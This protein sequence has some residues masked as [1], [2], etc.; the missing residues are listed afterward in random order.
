MTVGG[1]VVLV[2][3]FTPSASHTRHVE[4]VRILDIIAIVSGLVVP[5]LLAGRHSWLQ[6]LVMLSATL[7]VTVA[8]LGSGGG[9]TAVG[10]ASVYT[11]VVV[12][13]FFALSR[14]GAVAHLLTIILVGAP[15]LHMQAG[16]RLAEQIVLWGVTGLISLM[17]AWLI[18]VHDQSETDPLTGLPDRKGMDRALDRAL[19][20]PFG[21][22][23]HQATFGLL[24]LD[25]FTRFNTHHGAGA[26]DD[27]LRQLAT[28]WTRA[29]PDG[30]VLG[31]WSGDAFAV[32]MPGRSGEE[33]RAVCEQLRVL[34]PDGASVSAGVAQW[35][36]TE[37]QS[38]L[39]A[40]AET[41][42]YLAKQSG[43]DRVH[44]HSGPGTDGRDVRE[45]LAKIE[46][47]VHF[48][49]VVDLSTGLVQGAEALVRWERP[50][51]GLV[52]PDEFLPE[53]ET[54]GAIVELG[55]WVLREACH[56]AATWAPNAAGHL[57]HVAVNASGR[58]LQD[59]LYAVTV[60]EALLSSGLAPS[61]LIIELVESDYDIQTVELSDNLHALRAMGV[62]TAIDDFGTGSSSLERVRRLGADILKI[63]KSFVSDI[64]CAQT[65]APL[66]AA[67][68]AMASAMGMQ[69]VAEGVEHTY[70][71]DWL[72]AHGCE[73]GQGWLFGRPV[74]APPTAPATHPL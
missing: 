43:R 49:P 2:S 22:S 3:T 54:S 70:Q 1:A 24:N 23:D 10:Y 37:T 32:V 40:R 11:P 56:R 33:G 6:H 44:Q 53:A 13:G 71:R 41:A 50:S 17:V 8:I 65:K 4:L 61:R 26:G 25:H 73:F 34:M 69:V 20:T 28:I 66:V 21:A 38:M 35:H 46:F 27:L 36:P 14:L 57:P 60:R 58:E 62:R 51:R 45:G 29:L 47:R 12:Y 63:D 74:P 42:L 30:A 5:R 67:A 59:P 72:A 31:R 52:P 48:Q 68:L 55:G 9:G 64:T 15:V 18:S 7:L 19:H 16:V 39:V